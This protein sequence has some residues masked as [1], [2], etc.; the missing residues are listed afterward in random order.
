MKKFK[1]PLQRL[2]DVTV[3]R[4]KAVRVEVLSLTRKVT[5]TRREI[6]ERQARVRDRLCQ[7]DAQGGPGRL[8]A[9]AM[10]I[11]MAPAVHREIAALQNRL[12]LLVRQQ[13]DLRRQYV[14]IHRSRE[15]LER[16][17]EEALQKHRREQER[18][19]QASL[20]EG[21]HAGFVRRRSVGPA[22]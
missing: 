17:C 14:S 7:L 21:A 8:E 1:W 4:E 12:E 22:A 5:A 18:I 20:D 11:R 3:Q 13:G 16:A 9:Q 2:L 19:E 15:A 10:F 6:F